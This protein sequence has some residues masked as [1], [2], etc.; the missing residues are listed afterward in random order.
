MS[1]E[2]LR[3]KDWTLNLTGVVWVDFCERHQ[4][5]LIVIKI[6]SNGGNW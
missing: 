6:L 5:E 1:M 4:I 3:T 2:D